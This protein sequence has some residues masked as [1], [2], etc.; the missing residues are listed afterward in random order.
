MG[1][2]C[3]LRLLQICA[4]FT[5]NYVKGSRHCALVCGK[6][7]A[8]LVNGAQQVDL[9]ENMANRLQAKTSVTTRV[10]HSTLDPQ[11]T[12]KHFLELS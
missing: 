5:Q 7:Q 11:N 9:S 3:W 6:L 2:V 4:T 8:K 1:V 10:G 12:Q